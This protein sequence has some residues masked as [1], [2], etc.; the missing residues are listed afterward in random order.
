MSMSNVDFTRPEYKLFVL[1]WALVRTVCK[2]DDSV[3]SYLPILEESNKE[4]KR[5]RNSDYQDRAVFYPITGHTRNG[6][7]GMAFK[8][9]RWLRLTKDWLI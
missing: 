8:K 2:G 3:K 4:R 5:K 9:I 7:I 6:M 1:Q